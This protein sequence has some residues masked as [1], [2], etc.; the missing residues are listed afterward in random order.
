MVLTAWQDGDTSSLASAMEP[1]VVFS[2]PAFDYSGRRAVVHMFG[3]IS[4]VLDEID[5]VGSWCRDHDTLYRFDARVA[6][7]EVQGIVHEVR[8][9]AGQLVHV[10][11][12]LRPFV[13][14]R[15]AMR[16]MGQL[17]EQSPLPAP[18]A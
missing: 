13:V 4:Q 5:P 11:L 16:A 2:S 17:L 3:L 15:D 9:D 6:G 18:P 7:D 14:L 8:N 10:T 1:D 12:F